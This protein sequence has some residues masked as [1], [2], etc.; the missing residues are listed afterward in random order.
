M[1]RK[2]IMACSIIAASFFFCAFKFIGEQTL[3]TLIITV[4][5]LYFG[6]N[7]ADRKIPGGKA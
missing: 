5:G 4:C 2:F 1:S 3:A 7:V 6:S